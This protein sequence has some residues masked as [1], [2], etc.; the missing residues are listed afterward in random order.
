MA[1]YLSFANMV[2]SSYKRSEKNC[3]FLLMNVKLLRIRA[4]DPIL[5]L[6]QVAS[7]QGLHRQIT[8]QEFYM[9]SELNL[10]NISHS[11]IYLYLCLSPPPSPVP[12]SLLP[13]R[14]VELRLDLT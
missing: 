10:R 1:R 7:P 2:T 3:V 4:F 6:T 12:P 9:W 13:F 8:G 14:H 5:T 11:L